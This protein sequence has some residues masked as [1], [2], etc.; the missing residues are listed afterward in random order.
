VYR[1]GAVADAVFLDRRELGEGAGEG[2]VEEDRV[3]AEAAGAARGAGD[4]AG[5][6][7]LGD[8][9]AAIGVGDHDDAAEARGALGVGHG[10][11]ALEQQG[12]VG[13][14]VAGGAAAG[15]G[16]EAGGAD[17]CPAA[18]SSPS[19]TIATRVTIA[20]SGAS[21]ARKTCSVGL[22]SSTGRA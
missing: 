2:W 9:L 21:H 3:V 17:A 19:A 8:E 22:R 4:D 1:R 16:G 20:G 7:A 11:Q 5:A 6:G 10:S 18:S 12:E 13:G 14:V 15:V